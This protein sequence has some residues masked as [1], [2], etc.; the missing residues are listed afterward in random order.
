MK[1]IMMFVFALCAFQV[2]A[3]T[4]FETC[5]EEVVAA[6]SHNDVFVAQCL[7]FYKNGETPEHIVGQL[8]QEDE[9]QAYLVDALLMVT[10]FFGLV[11]VTTAA[12]IIVAELQISADR[13]KQKRRQS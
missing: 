5:V 13:E 1:K 4:P 9:K 7:S 3:T 12:S 2:H 8:V 10:G 11:I 6:L